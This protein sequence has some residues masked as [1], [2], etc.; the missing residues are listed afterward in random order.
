MLQNFRCGVMW[1]RIIEIG[2]EQAPF[3]A[4]FEHVKSLLI[5]SPNN[6]KNSKC[7]FLIIN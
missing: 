6:T 1:V 3:F 2:L 5:M 4:S 7:D